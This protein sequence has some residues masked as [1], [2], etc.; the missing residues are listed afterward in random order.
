MRK[1]RSP[2]PPARK[3]GKFEMAHRGTLFLDEIGDLPLPLQAKILRALEEKRFERVGGTVSLQVDV[4]VVAATN[5][6]LK[7]AVAAR[8]Y[9][10]DLYFRLSVFPIT[11]PP[12]RER[13]DDIP[14]LAKYFIERFCRDL[15]KKPLMLAPS[16]VQ[17][18]GVYSWPGNVRELQNCIE[19]AVILT[20]GDTIHARHLNLSFRDTLS[21]PTPQ[22]GPWDQ[23]DLSGTLAEASRRDPG[24]GRAPE[25][26]AGAQG[27]GRQQGPRRRRAAG[28]L[29]DVHR[30]TQGIRPRMRLLRPLPRSMTRPLSFAMLLA[31][32]G[33]MAVVDQP[34]VPVRPRPARCRPTS[35]NTVRPPSGTASTTAARRSD[36]PSV[37]PPGFGERV[38]DSRRRSAPDV[39]ARRDDRRGDEDD[40]AKSTETSRCG[41][42]SSRSIP[43]PA[44]LR[45]A[46][47][48]NA[49][50]LSSDALPPDGRHHIG[51]RHPAA[52]DRAG[53]TADDEPQLLA[54]SCQ[55]RTCSLGRG[56][57]GRMFDPATLTN[58]PVEAIVG[59]RAIVRAG[60]TSV[61]GVPRRDDRSR[62]CRRPRGSP[63]PERSC[64]KRVRSA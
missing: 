57:S 10:E 11:I 44:R 38:P 43:A 32:V 9:R 28:Q 46:D 62:D 61:P 33:C 64:E 29:Q 8:Q 34:R 55:Q 16:A 39:V 41:R 54:D 51:R 27:R 17:E 50:R 63:T 58:A 7:A 26:R 40:G 15:N 2:A 60:N 25:D 47:R 49:R 31:W 42:S 14:M 59:S 24:R 1:A 22:E 12:L 6:N 30:Q 23:I 36:S 21:P 45:F 3:P 4:R 53:R 18:L 56:T 20:E 5:R 37:R 35:R 48:S 52:S 19:R 13:S